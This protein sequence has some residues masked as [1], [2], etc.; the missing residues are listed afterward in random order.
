MRRLLVAWWRLTHRHGVQ[1][2]GRVRPF[3]PV[4]QPQEAAE[5]LASSAAT[6]RPS[7]SASTLHSLSVSLE[8]KCFSMA[9]RYVGAL[10][11]RRLRPS[12]V[13]AVN[14]DLLSSGFD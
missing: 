1:P 3:V 4:A 7:A 5:G 10:A 14:D 9:A 12:G 6:T 8:R 2:V 11:R 13:M